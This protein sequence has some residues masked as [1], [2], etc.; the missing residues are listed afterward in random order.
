MLLFFAITA[1]AFFQLGLC[2]FCYHVKQSR[3]A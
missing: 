1:T 2:F 3:T